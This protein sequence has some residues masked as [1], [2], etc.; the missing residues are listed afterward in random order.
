[1]S[2]SVDDLCPPLLILVNQVLPLPLLHPSVI[3][4]TAT[5]T[6]HAVAVHADVV[7]LLNVVTEEVLAT[8]AAQ[9]TVEDIATAICAS[10]VAI[11][12]KKLWVLARVWRKHL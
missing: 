5:T 7:R 8:L 11:V 6:T 10:D 1:V 3:R 4:L 2:I 9:E 12:W